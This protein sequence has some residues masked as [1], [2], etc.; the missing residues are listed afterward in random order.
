MRPTASSTSS[1]FTLKVL[2]KGTDDSLVADGCIQE[3]SCKVTID[4]GASVTI[5][6]PDIVAG[7]LE[8]S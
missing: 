1:R 8:R 7:M 5:N 3:R 4:T 2:A 6:K